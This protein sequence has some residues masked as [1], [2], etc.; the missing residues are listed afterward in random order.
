LPSADARFR[1]E[2][3]IFGRKRAQTRKLFRVSSL[4]FRKT[5]SRRTLFVSSPSGAVGAS[6]SGGAISNGLAALEGAV[7]PVASGGALSIRLVARRLGALGK[8]GAG[9][10]SSRFLGRPRRG[11]TGLQKILQTVE[12]QCATVQCPGRPFLFISVPC[13]FGAQRAVPF[14]VECKGALGEGD[15]FFRL[16]SKIRNVAS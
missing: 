14:H 5:Q 7:R 2:G 1:N 11:G 9:E 10:G 3:A 12:P 16:S 4:G 13:R 8:T 6:L 15:K